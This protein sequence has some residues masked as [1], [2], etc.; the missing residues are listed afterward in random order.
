MMSSYLSN[1]I[2][3][4]FKLILT[5]PHDMKLTF[6]LFKL[7]TEI[8]AIH[9]DDMKVDLDECCDFDDIFQCAT[10]AGYLTIDSMTSLRT[11][12]VCALISEFSKFTGFCINQ[13]VINKE[14]SPL[15]II[16]GIIQVHFDSYHGS[17]M[18]LLKSW[19]QK[20]NGRDDNGLLRTF[21][22]FIETKILFPKPNFFIANQGPIFSTHIL[23]LLQATHLISAMCTQWSDYWI[24]FLRAP[25]DTAPS[26][27]E[28]AAT[29]AYLEDGE[30]DSFQTVYIAVGKAVKEGLSQEHGKEYLKIMCGYDAV[31]MFERGP[32]ME[33]EKFLN[34]Q[35]T[36]IDLSPETLLTSHELFLRHRSEKNHTLLKLWRNGIKVK[37]KF[38]ADIFLPQRLGPVFVSRLTLKLKHTEMYA[39]RKIHSIL[40]PVNIYAKRVPL[41]FPS[42]NLQ[43]Q[44][45]LTDFFSDIC[46]N[47]QVLPVFKTIS[48]YLVSNFKKRITCTFYDLLCMQIDSSLQLDDKT[49]FI[50]RKA[51]QIP[52]DVITVFSVRNHQRNVDS[53]IKDI[54]HEDAERFYNCELAVFEGNVLDLL[55]L[56]DF[57]R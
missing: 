50:D 32:L 24:Q 5:S 51:V 26:A 52:W 11:E 29:L 3:D 46:A 31:A 35:C 55:T 8:K 38:P 18:L 1:P 57:D 37:H 4:V 22:D 14:K 2:S 7:C 20:L 45:D 43:I 23:V 30:N 21:A 27:I 17:Y 40:P 19:V 10:S 49:I 28:L 44:T 15:S 25:Y 36:I 12:V 34:S 53:F 6:T 9:G 48:N 56:V 54:I 47:V 39:P 41:Y 42:G 33:F 13:S 16:I